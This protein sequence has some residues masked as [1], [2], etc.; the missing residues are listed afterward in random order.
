M[1]SLKK[2]SEPST[3]RSINEL[4][5]ILALERIVARFDRHPKLSQG[6]VF[7]G[8]FVLLK[9]LKAPRFTHDVDALAIGLSRKKVPEYVKEAIE[10]D[11]NDG[12]WFGDIKKT[13]DLK[14]QGQYG[15]GGYRF[16]VAF[17][18]GTASHQ[19]IQNYSRV[20]VDIG[21]GDA[22]EAI[23]KKQPMPSILTLEQPITWSIY[24]F[25]YIFAEKLEALFAKGSS[26]TRAKDIFDMSLVFKLCTNKKK[27]RKAIEDT[28]KGRGTKIPDSFHLVA[29]E[30]DLD[31]LKR[32]W[33]AV[34]QMGTK[35]SF[36]T[37]WRTFLS[38]LRALDS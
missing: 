4:R 1:S 16:S 24:P 37:S 19:K 31:L 2:M 32:A 9:T 11:L 22:L 8:G 6:L 30:Y 3:G 35:V 28:F 34:E 38:V 33:T 36:E 18:I 29:K 26:N 14:G 15:G 13:D 20:D 17:Q 12:F 27:L 5:L 25:E 10:L 7:K 21:F 23:P